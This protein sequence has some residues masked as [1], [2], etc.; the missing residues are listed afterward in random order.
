MSDR[1]PSSFNDALIDVDPEIAAV[2]DQELSRQRHTLEM[3]ATG[4]LEPPRGRVAILT[5]A[6]DAMEGRA[7]P[8]K[9]SVVTFS[10]SCR[11]AILDV[12]WR[13]SASGICAGAMPQPLSAMAMRFTPSAETWWAIIG[14][15]SGPS[16]GWPPVIA[17]ASLKRI[18]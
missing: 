2:L 4:K 15:S 17:T 9:P 14:T 8:R 12:A 5:R 11:L 10:R 1:L 13:A 7:S 3:I 16:I 6:T 18:L